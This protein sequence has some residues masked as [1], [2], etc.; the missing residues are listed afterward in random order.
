[1]IVSLLIERR[2]TEPI[3]VNVTSAKKKHK[4]V[5]KTLREF[6]T[7]SIEVLFYC[8]CSC[9]DADTGTNSQ[10]VLILPNV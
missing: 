9:A 4:V 3:Q 8:E 6:I 1:M 10:C 2:D 7:L 5:E